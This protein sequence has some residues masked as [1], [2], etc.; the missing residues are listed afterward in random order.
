MSCNILY[1]LKTSQP[2]PLNKLKELEWEPAFVLWADGTWHDG[3]Q[4]PSQV[5]MCCYNSNTAK[6]KNSRMETL[7]FLGQKILDKE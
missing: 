6:N 3:S 5:P 2:K 7:T 1:P 4:S